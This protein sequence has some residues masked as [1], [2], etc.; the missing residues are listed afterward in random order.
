[1]TRLDI[2][3]SGKKVKEGEIYRPCVMGSSVKESVQQDA[4]GLDAHGRL[5]AL[6]RVLRKASCPSCL[7]VELHLEAQEPRRDQPGRL[8]PVV[9][10][11]LRRQ[12]VVRRE[13]GLVA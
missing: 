4:R 2:C 6:I 3:N 13:C 10:L 1:M 12:R 5:R 11:N 7:E 9:H 8:Q